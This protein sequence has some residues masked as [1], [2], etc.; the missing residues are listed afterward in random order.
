MNNAFHIA[1]IGMHA[2]QT[3]VET[4]A[5]NLANI[6]TQG[7]KAARVNFQDLMQ[8]PVAVTG[9]PAAGMLGVDFSLIT[10]D[11]RGGDLKATES[12]LDLAISGVG[13]FEVSQLDGSRAYTRG[14]TFQINQ[15]GLLT[16]AQGAVLKPGIQVPPSYSKLAISPDGKVL[17]TMPGGIEPVEI[18]R[19]E[20]ASFAN[21]GELKATG[22]GLYLPTERSGDALHGRPGEDG[23]GTLAQQRLE[24]S[25]VKMVDEM[26]NLMMAQK[27]YGLNSK[28]LQV[29][30]EM[31]SMINNLRR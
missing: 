17:V 28:V 1:V 11:F 29:S 22:E 20:L 4:V 3:G 21:P 10:K 23:L 26:V 13:F 15:D 5:N 8:A 19:L 12:P 30:D 25:N 31:M 14:G 16:P 27:A 24:G 7:F 18:G 2:Q 9:G 6:S